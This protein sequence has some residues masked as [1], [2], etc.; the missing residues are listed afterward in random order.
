MATL[1]RNEIQSKADQLYN[2]FVE[3]FKKKVDKIISEESAGTTAVYVGWNKQTGPEVQETDMTGILAVVP[4]GYSY[5]FKERDAFTS[6]FAAFSK[7]PQNL[8]KELGDAL[9]ADVWLVYVFS[10]EGTDWNIGNA[11]KVKVLIDYLLVSNYVVS[12]EKTSTEITNMFDK[13]K[14][15]VGLQTSIILTRGKRSIGGSAESQYTGLLKK[16]WR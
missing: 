2:D 12:V 11:A 8:S 16:I 1:D 7:T 10:D 3:E 5:Y 6:I 13:C 15:A 9:I 14:Q 4:K